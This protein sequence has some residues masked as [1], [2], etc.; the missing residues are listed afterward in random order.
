MS[1]EKTMHTTFTIQ[2]LINITDGEFIGEE[3]I[4]ALKIGISTDTRTIT[5]N[6]VY[7]ALVGE[8]FDGHEFVNNAFEKGA[9]LAVIDE[10][11]SDITKAGNFLIVKN[12]LEAYLKIAAFHRQ[13]CSAKIIGVTGSSGKTTTLGM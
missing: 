7:L 13:R 3:N 11:H 6:D 8:V 2:E 5:E 1:K 4:L 9:K 10:K 12:T